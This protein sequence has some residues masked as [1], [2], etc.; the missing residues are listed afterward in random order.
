MMFNLR[1]LVDN[2]DNNKLSFSCGLLISNNTSKHPSFRLDLHALVRL[3]VFETT[4]ILGAILYNI[5]SIKCDFS[6]G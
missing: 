3:E 6:F 4:L 5:Y 2:S 1:N